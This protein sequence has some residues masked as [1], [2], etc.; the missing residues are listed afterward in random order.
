MCIK[1]LIAGIEKK[2][3]ILKTS[4]TKPIKTE[5]NTKAIKNFSSFFINKN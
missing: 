2:I 5:I 4:K 3:N 1:K